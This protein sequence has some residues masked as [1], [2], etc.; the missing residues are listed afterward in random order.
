MRI[1][2]VIGAPNSGKTTF[3]RE[4]FP[5]LGKTAFWYE[6][7]YISLPNPTPRNPHKKTIPQQII[8]QW[9]EMSQDRTTDHKI[10]LLSGLSTNWQELLTVSEKVYWIRTHPDVIM[11]RADER[12]FIDKKLLRTWAE[13]WYNGKNAEW[14]LKLIHKLEIVGD[15]LLTCQYF[16]HNP[17]D[18]QNKILDDHIHACTH[19]ANATHRCGYES[20]FASKHCLFY[21]PMSKKAPE[22]DNAPPYKLIEYTNEHFS[23]PRIFDQKHKC[24]ICGHHLPLNQRVQ[25]DDHYIHSDNRI[26]LQLK[27]TEKGETAKDEPSR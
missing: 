4:L 23:D 3:A 22:M 11:S 10:L 7:D 20:T 12:P 9:Y 13:D 18:A 17:F 8:K 1:V 14:I 24:D 19:S 6:V 26:C 16:N 2:H 5:K 15:D 25:I 21:Q 27:L